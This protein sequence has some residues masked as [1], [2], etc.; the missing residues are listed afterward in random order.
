LHANFY[1]STNPILYLCSILLLVSITF[2]VFEA[3]AE[4]PSV[5]ISSESIDIDDFLYLLDERDEQIYD[6]ISKFDAGVQLSG[7]SKVIK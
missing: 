5:L 6:G 4:E 7:I 3:S 1:S 2:Y